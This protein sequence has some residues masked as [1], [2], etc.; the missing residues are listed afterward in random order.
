MQDLGAVV[1]ALV[2]ELGVGSQ[3]QQVG[4]ERHSYRFQ[5]TFVDLCCHMP[6]FLQAGFICPEAP[7]ITHFQHLQRSE[8]REDYAL[9]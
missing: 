7:E 4:I 3:T 5:R 9:N 8:L 2:I 1:Q 6:L